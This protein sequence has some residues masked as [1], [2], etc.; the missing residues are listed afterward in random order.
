MKKMRFMGILTAVMLL[1]FMITGC[2]FGTR[3][4]GGEITIAAPV[5]G[6]RPATSATITGPSGTTVTSVTW[7]VFNP[8]AGTWTVHSDATDFAVGGTYRATINLTS[9]D[10]FDLACSEAFTVAGA[11]SVTNQPGQRDNVSVLV[12]FPPAML[13]VVTAVTINAVPNAGAISSVF[14]N[15]D[16]II[17]SA[18]PVVTT[19]IAT[20]SAATWERS[21]DGTNWIPA[22]A[23]FEV[24]YFFRATITLQATTN[25]TF[26][27]NFGIG[28]IMVNGGHTTAVDSLTVANPGE[29]GNSVTFRV[30]WARTVGAQYVITT[31]LN[32]GVTAFAGPPI[33][34]ATPAAG[35]I[36]ITLEHATVVS[37]GLGNAL[38]W[39]VYTGTIPEGVT[40]MAAGTAG[41][42]TITITFGGP[43]T[44]VSSASITGINI[45]AAATSHTAD[46]SVTFVTAVT[47]ASTP[48]V[49]GPTLGQ[50]ASTIDTTVTAG[51]TITITLTATTTTG[52]V[53]TTDTT[54]TGLQT[55]VISGIG[56]A[57][58]AGS[59]G[60]INAINITGDSTTAAPVQA[61][62]AAGEATVTLV[63]HRAA[64]HNAIT[65]GISGRGT[66]ATLT[67][68]TVEHGIPAGDLYIFT[69]PNAPT[70]TGDTSATP[71]ALNPMPVI[72]IRDSFGNITTTGPGATYT[73]TVAFEDDGGGPGAPA[74]LSGMTIATAVGGIA[75]FAGTLLGTSANDDVTGIELV[76]SV[77]G[78]PGNV[79]SN[80]FNFD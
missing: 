57:S 24:G 74:I 50:T 15:R 43:P 22:L 29:T 10:G 2:D 5:A 47:L 61:N 30:T 11:I 71:L 53:T 6:V 40:A 79:I 8:T 31:A 26:Q 21:T 20:A 42:T 35:V 59:R 28:N 69:Q 39:L 23:N 65:I 1:S 54:V 32:G 14:H 27:A 77:L 12:V 18:T 16:N 38:D 75:T 51:N 9:N 46:I 13:P 58:G 37:A 49:A 55:I 67:A 78:A 63:L 17:A 33:V 52:G 80:Q 19:S 56:A 73:V 48:G 4:T 62:F 41:M 3:I 68:V 45:P 36:T 76:F 64:V 34:A 7:S 44:S 72:H 60:T 25:H 70:R 66:P